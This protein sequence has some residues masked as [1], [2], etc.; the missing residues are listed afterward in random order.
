[1]IKVNVKQVGLA[2]GA[3]KKTK[4]TLE[5]KD[6]TTVDGALKIV[7]EKYGERFERAV[8][9]ETMVNGKSVKTPNVFL[10]KA[11]IQ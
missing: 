8:Y 10:N 1:M 9:A 3:T 2:V 6:K 11:R 5:L 7:C 4:K